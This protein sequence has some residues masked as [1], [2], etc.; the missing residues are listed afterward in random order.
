MIIRLKSKKFEYKYQHIS[1]ESTHE[2][3]LKHFDLIL[4]FLKVFFEEPKKDTLM[5]V[6]TRGI[7]TKKALISE[8]FFV[9]LQGLEP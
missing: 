3:P 9:G 7:D 2:E 4:T 5:T 1:F 8:S 6:K